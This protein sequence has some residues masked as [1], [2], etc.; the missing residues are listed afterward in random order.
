MPEL[1]LAARLRLVPRSACFALDGWYV[2]C[3]TICRTPEG[4]YALL[5]SRWPQA[6]G[7][8]GWVTDSE[9]GVALADAPTGPF[10]CEGVVLPGAGGEVWDAQVTHNPAVMQWE[11]KYYLYYMGTRGERE[12]R[13]TEAPTEEEYWLHRNNQ[14]IGVAVADDPR[15]PWQR[16]DRPLI[17]VN[18]QSWDYMIASNPTVCPTPDGRFLMIYKTCT[19]G[20]LPFGGEVYHAAAFADSP[21]GPFTR[22]PDPIFTCEGVKFPAEDP[23]VWWQEDRYCAVVKDMQGSFT[24]QGPGLVLFDSPDGVDWRLARHAFVSARQVVWEGGPVQ[25]VALLD[26]PQVYVEDGRPRV[27]SCA[28]KPDQGEALSYNVQ[29]PLGPPAL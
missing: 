15:G 3:G 19:R 2:W 26:R 28:V 24:A 7:F 1:D 10:A 9:V 21:T 29:V 14:R 25:P 18:R 11:G 6:T 17:D 23:C 12:R 27:L 8:R 16:F 5:F 13:G 22:L 4:R 20:P